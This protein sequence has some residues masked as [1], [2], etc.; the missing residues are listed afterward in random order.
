M[1]TRF[2][3]TAA[4]LVATTAWSQV[5]ISEPATNPV[6]SGQMLAPPA[7]SSAG[8]STTL[9]AD[10]RSNYL[11]AG[12]IFATEYSDNVLSNA[13]NPAKDVDYSVY[14]VIELDKRTARMSFDG[15]YGPGFTTYQ[16]TSR[17]NLIGQNVGLNFQYRLTPHVTLGLTDYFRE[18]S[19]RLGAPPLSEGAVPGAP[20]L[21]VNAVLGPVGSLLSNN[22]SAELTYQFARNGMVGATGSAETLHYL[23]PNE[24]VG[25]YDSSGRG[26]SAFY[27]H[28]VSKRH[29]IGATYQYQRTLAFPPNA[30]S[31][32]ES[33]TIFLFYTL[34]LKPQLSVSITGGPQHYDL[35]Q[36]PLPVHGSWSPTTTASVAWQGLHTAAAV[37]YTHVVTGGGGLVGA[38]QTEN[39]TSVARWRFARTWNVGLAASYANNKSITPASFLTTEGGHSIF[40]TV[41]AKHE[42]T[43]RLQMEFGYTRLHENYGFVPSIST[44]P[45]TD[46]FFISFAYRISR[47]LGG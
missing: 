18:T 41:S 3:L 14:P 2:C 7:V 38:F 16:R 12:L 6:S 35:S 44:A 27:N 19:N 11:R 4:M 46:R 36:P 34:Y 26:A 20:V 8:F 37:S 39:A 30:Q 31:E 22:A 5:P 45:N 24:V 28:R 25:L 1:L 13:D 15:S 10:S 17:L 47:P 32:V 9:G 23:N 42:L 33:H 40:A 29:Y 43:E 21:P